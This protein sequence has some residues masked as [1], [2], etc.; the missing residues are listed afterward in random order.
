MNNIKTRYKIIFFDNDG[1]LNTGRSTWEYLHKYFGTWEPVGRVLQEKLHRNRTPYDEYSRQVTAIWK[2]I[3]RDR[4]IERLGEI[5]A[6]PGAVELV[7]S[8]SASGIKVA[9]LSS[10]FTLWQDVWRIRAGLEFDYY[11]AN[12]IIFDDDGFCTGEIIMRVTDN[13]P[14]MDK[15]NWV[16]KISDELGIPEEDRVFVGDGW[17]DVPG[18][19]KC[20]LSIAVNPNMPEV[21][22]AADHVLGGDE[23][24]KVIDLII[25]Q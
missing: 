13:V 18:F 21:V 15:G 6:R 14:G 19:K 20:G 11:Q 24:S 5:D 9:L 3:H 8:L 1:T 10:G 4:F 23:I 25:A 22:E 17:G 12:E 7:R 16:E 2:G